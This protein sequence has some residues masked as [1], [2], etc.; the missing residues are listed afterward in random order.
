[1]LGACLVSRVTDFQRRFG[2]TVHRWLVSRE[3]SQVIEWFE[4]SVLLPCLLLASQ[5]S[6]PN[7]TDGGTSVLRFCLPW[8]LGSFVILWVFSYSGLEHILPLVEFLCP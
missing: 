2:L 5:R 1:M 7:H 3:K 6:S 8:A 4:V